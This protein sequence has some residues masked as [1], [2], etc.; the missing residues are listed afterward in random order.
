M[1]YFILIIIVV[2]GVFGIL[3]ANYE[4]EKTKERG[5]TLKDKMKSFPDFHASV[6]ISGVRNMYLFSVDNVNKKIMLLDKLTNTI[7]PFDKIINVELMED[8]TILSSKSLLRTVGGTV[9]G[10]ALAGGAGAIVGGLSRSQK[11]E[12][13]VSKVQVK[14]RLR[15]ISKSSLTITC[16]DSETMTTGGKSSIKTT[17]MEGY[18]YKQGFEHAKKIC[19]IISVI[20]DEV[21][22]NAQDKKTDIINENPS[23][24]I[25][26]IEKLVELKDKGALTDEEFNKM[27]SSILSNDTNSLSSFKEDNIIETDELPQDIKDA[28]V[29]N[30]KILAIKL[31]K[32]YKNCSLKEAKDF[33]DN[34]REG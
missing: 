34:F 7:V 17:S 21:N 31:Y 2:G 20:I 16:F 4:N 29:S 5:N 12:K 23:S 30:Q 8:N 6:T 24:A 11:Q 13:K 14:I 3:G 18:I 10:G 1:W 28:I 26:Q 25:E 9:V 33:V 32:D 19:D 15:D 27:K 22:H